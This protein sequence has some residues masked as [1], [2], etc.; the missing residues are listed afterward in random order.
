[1]RDN[2]YREIQEMKAKRQVLFILL[3]LVSIVGIGIIAL[4]VSLVVN[5]LAL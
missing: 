1:M 4:M 3:G 5:L 2:T